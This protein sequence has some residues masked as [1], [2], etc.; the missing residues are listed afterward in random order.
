VRHTTSSLLLGLLALAA[1]ACGSGKPTQPIIVEPYVLDIRWLGDEPDLSVRQAFGRA[2][3]R[4]QSII[5]GGLSPVLLP[6]D[7]NVEQCDPALTGFANVPEQTVEG[8]II[9]VLVEEI[10]GPGDILGSAGPCLVRDMDMNKPALGIMRLD[11]EDLAALAAQG[12]LDALILHETLHVVGFGTVWEDN[13]LVA[14]LN[15][16]DAQFTGP[17]AREACANVN[18][19]VNTCATTVPVHSEG[20]V[21]S[22]YA[23]WRETTFTNE[24]MTLGYEVNVSSADAYAVA[25]GLRVAESNDAAAPPVELPA[26]RAPRFKLRPDGTMRPFIQ[27]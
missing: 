6:P 14:G 7:F 3:T 21:G 11:E 18:G 25:A 27:R 15:T 5:T 8:L 26:P 2:E 10:D 17:N 4:I 23:H 12:R 22:A 16:P 24:L 20:G 9:Y 1:S 13:A 19:G